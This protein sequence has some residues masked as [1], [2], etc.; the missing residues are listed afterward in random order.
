MKKGGKA[1]G[2]WSCKILDGWSA[3]FGVPTDRYYA[4]V[5]FI[6]STERVVGTDYGI[7]NLVEMKKWLPVTNC[8]INTKNLNYLIK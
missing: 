5:D 1:N 4:V 7:D 8:G 2:E 3:G 6:L